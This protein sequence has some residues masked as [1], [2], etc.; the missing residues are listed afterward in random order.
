M[1]VQNYKIFRYAKN[2]SYSEPRICCQYVF[3]VY[4]YIL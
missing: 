1:S 4:L 3:F 2:I